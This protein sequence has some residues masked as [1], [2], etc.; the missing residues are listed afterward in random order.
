MVR[1]ACQLGVGAAVAQWQLP[2]GVLN[3][4]TVTRQH[5]GRDVMNPHNPLARHKKATNTNAAIR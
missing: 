5:L 2:E 4:G 1:L 3:M